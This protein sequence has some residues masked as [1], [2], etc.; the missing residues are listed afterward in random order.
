MGNAPNGL[1]LKLTALVVD[2]EAISTCVVCTLG[3]APK[4]KKNQLHC[5][6]IEPGA[7]R[8]CSNGN[9][10]GYH[11]PNN[12]SNNSFDSDIS[13]K[14]NLPLVRLHSSARELCDAVRHSLGWNH[15]YCRSESVSLW[16]FPFSDIFPCRNYGRPAC[17]IGLAS[18]KLDLRG[19]GDMSPVGSWGSHTSTCR[20]RTPHLH[21]PAEFR[22]FSSVHNNLTEK[23]YRLSLS[24]LRFTLSRS[25]HRSP[26]QR[27]PSRSSQRESCEGRKRTTGLSLT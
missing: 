12:A 22:C 26:A 21:H 19:S 15:Q 17:H 5:P 18:E 3:S 16:H 14:S 9:D 8:V 24:F 4:K 20:S 6:G 23:M 27:K 11:Y 10:P 25:T 13:S 7:G 1:Q 2:L